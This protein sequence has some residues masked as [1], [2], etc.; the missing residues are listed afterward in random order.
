MLEVSVAKRRET[1]RKDENEG[2]FIP[3]PTTSCLP[4][5]QILPMP[6]NVQLAIPLRKGRNPS[7]ANIGDC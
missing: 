6:G 4:K 7:D 3:T 2:G 1:R 5:E